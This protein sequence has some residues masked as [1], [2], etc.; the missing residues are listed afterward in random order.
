MEF[1]YNIYIS[2]L[3]FVKLVQHLVIN[4]VVVCYGMLFI[5]PLRCTLDFWDPQNELKINSLPS[6][7]ILKQSLCMFSVF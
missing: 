5:F 3:D 6:Q 1:T 4:L 7:Y 2:I